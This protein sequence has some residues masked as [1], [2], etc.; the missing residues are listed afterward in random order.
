MI[1]LLIVKHFVCDFLLQ[2]HGN[3]KGSD[4]PSEWVPALFEHAWTHAVWTFLVCQAVHA[5]WWL[6]L[7]DLVLHF[8]IDRLKAISPW[9]DPKQKSFWVALGA[10]QMAHYLCYV[11]YA[12]VATGRIS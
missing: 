5:P 10:D 8:V 9:K 3:K 2:R 12:Y 1:T 6:A 11:A 7:V 4:L